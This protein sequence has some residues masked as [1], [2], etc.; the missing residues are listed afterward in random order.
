VKSGPFQI[1]CTHSATL[2]ATI[3]DTTLHLDYTA[4]GI[5]LPGRRIFIPI[6]APT[7]VDCA[8]DGSYIVPFGQGIEGSTTFLPFP[9]GWLFSIT[10][11]STPI[12]RT[13]R[14]TEW[15][16]W[17]D[18]TSHLSISLSKDRCQATLSLAFLPT[19]ETVG[20]TI[21][22]KDL[23]ANN[24]WGHL[25]AIA[26]IAAEGGWGDQTI[27]GY[28][29]ITGAISAIGGQTATAG[30]AISYRTRLQTP[31]RVRIY[32]LFVRLFGN[33]NPTRKPNGTLA[34]NGV[35]KFDDI[36]DHAI[37]A[38]RDLGCTHIWLT[39]IVRQMTA[40][41][42]SAIGLPADDPD[43]L[44]GLAGSPYAVKDGFD[45]CP[46]YAT[47]PARRMHEFKALV[48]RIRA[49][50]LQAIIDLVPNHVGRSYQSTV[51]PDHTY[52][53]KDDPG[54]FFA[55]NNNYYYLRPTDPGGGPPLRLPTVHNG[56]L[57]SPTCQVL[58]RG[59]GIY[60]PETEHGRVS[61]NNVVSWSPGITDWYET[62]KLNYGVDFTN[63][64]DT[65]ARLYPHGATP[66]FAI[67]DTWL[68]V[69]AAIAHWQ[70]LGVDGFRCDMAHMVPPEFWSWAIRRA[71]QRQPG[72]W[73]MAEAYNN[74]PA[75]L[76]PADPMLAAL[77]SVMD[78]LLNAGFNAVYDDPTYKAIKGIY[79][80]GKWAN[81]I[82]SAITQD[83]I[84]HNSLRYAENHDEVRLAVHSQ[85]AGLGMQVGRPVAAILFAIGRGPLM[86]YNGQEVGE[87]GSG[88]AGFAC[89][90]SR[91]TIFDYWSMPELNKWANQHKYDGDLL[92]KEQK[93]LRDYYA[94]LLK[95]SNEPGLRNG[96]FR[97]LNPANTDSANFGRTEGDPAAGHHIYAFLRHD[98]HSNQSWLIAANLH[99]TIEFQNIQIKI[100]GDHLNWL[101]LTNPKAQVTFTDRIA[102][103]ANPITTQAFTLATIGLTLPNLNPLSATY[104]EMKATNNS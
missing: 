27:P 104:L 38:I 23:T 99:P 93:D 16:P 53:E 36:N 34:E 25:F 102:P 44:K 4:P 26:D 57:I 18:A 49:H 48:A 89:D 56:K 15:G 91:T 70:A 82:T 31:D 62:V 35:G 45:V 66:D 78:S 61:G 22:S 103:S 63:P 100:P 2:R 21:Y 24:S 71:R 96:N 84:Y 11:N 80:W 28:H 69:D 98:P 94:K 51:S 52:G 8:P 60:E 72:V 81:D 29:R 77:D 7:A 83:F 79:D 87:T 40:T 46:D 30:G 14:E 85:W 1:P 37:A 97:P 20:L 13:W 58:G 68:K 32:Q 59:T 19:P 88:L 17:Q 33:S 101:G 73:F 67:P 95:L 64:N 54:K 3:Q 10:S 47:N 75:K 65:T 74:D 12:F 41:D 43:L 86:I 50:G 76:P 90:D 5:D 6:E 92:S 42:Y 55:P 39:G 9:A